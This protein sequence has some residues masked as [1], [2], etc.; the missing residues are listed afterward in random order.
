MI[1]QIVIKLSNEEYIKLQDGRISVNTMRKAL[2]DGTVLPEQH[3]RL[4][5]ADKLLVHK[6]YGIF[7]EAGYKTEAVYVDDINDAPTILEGTVKELNKEAINCDACKHKNDGW[8]SEHC[9]GCC[10][11]HSGF[12]PQE[13]SE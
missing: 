6:M 8:D 11:N 10:G 9:D 12:E 7:G 4:I 1:M 2:L 5:D 3:G 13:R